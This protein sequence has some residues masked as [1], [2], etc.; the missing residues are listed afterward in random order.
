MS[1][2]PDRRSVAGMLTSR[3]GRL[4]LLV[5]TVLAG[6]AL[7]AYWQARRS[8]AD[9]VATVRRGDLAV[10][11]SETGSLRPASAITYRSPLAGREAEV[12]FLAPEGLR[13]AEG[14]LLARI[15]ASE[16]EREL[17]RAVQVLRQAGVDLQIADAERIEAQS[18]VEAAADGEGALGEEEAKIAA[19]LAEQNVD[20][21]R[22]EHQSLRPL[23]EQGFITRE[24]MD[25]TAY[26]LSRA[27]ADLDLARRRLAVVAGRTRPREMQRARLQLAQQEARLAGTR[28]RL[29][30]AEVAVRDLRAAIDACS[31]YA[32]RPGLVVYEEYLGASPRR[33]VRVGDRVT[34]SQG[35]ITIPEVARMVVET[36]VRELDVG[37]VRPG[38]PVGI[39]LDAFPGPVLTG[40]VQRLG[41]LARTSAERPFEARR[42]DVVV[43]VDESTLDLRPDMTARVEIRVAERRNVLLLPP[44][45]VF[46]RDGTTFVRV[47]RP[48]G[49]ETRRVVVGE[50]GGADVE[51]VS[52]VCEGERVSL[53]EP[54][55]VP[56]PE[57]GRVPPTQP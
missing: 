3:R 40:R 10:V 29:A 7:L 46:E 12:V 6:I 41:T 4:G 30:E 35:L 56:L 1:A 14:D 15:D 13:V 8:G 54:D 11:L 18:A 22:R 55:P 25:R 31:V 38:Q 43:E 50:G 2:E 17:A 20:R 51:I 44:Y 52:G 9:P 28:P 45:A 33:K 21:L 42:F 26:E 27:E 57:D 24:E 19:T 48:W 23:L 47:V 5:T 37:R 16:L 32:K 36:S 39:R 53:A 34:S 49:L